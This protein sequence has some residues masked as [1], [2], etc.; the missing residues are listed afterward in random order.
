MGKRNSLVKLGLV[1][2]LGLGV[3]CSTSPKLTL[4]ER[5]KD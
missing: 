2:L 1:A 4:I 3:G 5:N